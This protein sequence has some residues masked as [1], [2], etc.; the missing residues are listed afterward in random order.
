MDF[1]S[2]LLYIF[3]MKENIDI[4]KSFCRMVEREF[5][6]KLCLH[7]YTGRLA[8]GEL[9]HMHFAEC[10]VAYKKSLRRRHL[11]CMN[12]DQ[13]I[14]PQK[15]SLTGRG[16]FK[17][18][19]CGILEAVFP[20]YTRN[21]LAGI[22]FAGPFAAGE[23]ELTVPTSQTVKTALPK[24]DGRARNNLML[25]GE[26][27]ASYLGNC[28]TPAF[29]T[30]R[31][32]IIR[33][34]IQHCANLPEA[35]LETLAEKLN[36]SPPRAGEAVKKLFG[37]SFAQLLTME[38]LRLAKLYLDDTDYPV[39]FIAVKAGFRDGSYFHRVF[40]R[41]C[42]MTPGEYRRRHAPNA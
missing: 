16:F 24:L 5:D 20:V 13:K 4:F 10:C 8:H 22:I 21:V 15:A 17:M 39:S 41:R 19:H 36:L 6:C 42:G 23:A 29:G 1:F 9:P 2:F 18:C 26:L 11:L 40:R 3:H 31:A 38:R 32:G 27:L 28:C 30:D 12:F 33:G 34:Y 7:D 14:V 35:C 25:M 37:K